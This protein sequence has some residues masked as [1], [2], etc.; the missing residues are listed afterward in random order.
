MTTSRRF[1]NDETEFQAWIRAHPEIDSLRHAVT[2]NDCDLV[3]QKYKTV[4]DGIGT[5]DVQLHM[6]VEVKTHSA[7]PN[8]TQRE[9][10]FD[11]HQLL[12]NKRRKLVSAIS[13]TERSVW[14]FGV[15]VLSLSGTAPDN[16]SRIDWCSFDSRGALQRQPIDCETLCGILRF[17][18]S[19]DDVKDALRLRRHHKTTELIRDERTPLGFVVPVVIRRSS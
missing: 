19:P 17:D 13:R 12:M 3:L 1:G 9:S 2:V 10:L 14:H 5:R 18:V 16:S 7:M 15:Y 11:H 6:W 8:N 4:V